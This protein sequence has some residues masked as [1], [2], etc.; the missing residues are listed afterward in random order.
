MC[1][2]HNFCYFCIYRVPSSSLSSNFQ[3]T[4]HKIE[5]Q[6]LVRYCSKR[7]PSTRD[8]A[9]EIC[10]AEGEGTI[11]YTTVSRWYKRFNSGD[12]SLE[13]QPHS[14]GHQR[15]TTKI[16]RQPWKMSLHQAAVN[17]RPFLGSRSIRLRSVICIKWILCTRSLTRIQTSCLKSKPSIVLKTTVNCWKVHWMIS[18]GSVLCLK[19]KNVST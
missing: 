15:W 6:V 10:D 4:L 5:L 12:L 19:T 11:H 2:T 14:A 1:F 3:V 16:C 9:K 18:F 17:C 13:D 7:R 8:A